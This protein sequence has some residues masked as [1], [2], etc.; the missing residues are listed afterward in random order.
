MC[1][2]TIGMLRDTL[3]VQSKVGFMLGCEAESWNR[4]SKRMVNTLN[5][6]PKNHKSDYKALD[7]LESKSGVMTLFNYC[8]YCGDKI[9][10]KAIKATL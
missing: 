10:W 9:D 4:H 5:C 8:P 7:I 3:I 2:H 1:D 6:D